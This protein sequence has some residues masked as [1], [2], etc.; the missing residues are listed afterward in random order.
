M[1]GS[2][3]EALGFLA[4]L[5]F[6]FVSHGEFGTFGWVLWGISIGVVLMLLRDRAN[7]NDE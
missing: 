6:A 2:L 5:W 4:F 3:L 7:N 1:K